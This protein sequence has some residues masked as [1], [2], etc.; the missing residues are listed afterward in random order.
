MLYFLL[1]AIIVIIVG[2]LSS[3]IFKNKQKKKAAN[4]RNQWGKVKSE[5]FNFNLISIYLENN[6]ESGFHQLSDQTKS[7]IDF[8]DI[9]CLIDRTVSK[10]GQQFLFDKCSRPTNDTNALEEL[11]KQVDFFVNNKTKR[12]VAQQLLASLNNNDAYFIATLLTDKLPPRPAWFN[13]AKVYIMAILLMAIAAV[14]YP[15]LIIWLMVPFGVNVFFHY[16]N[17]NHTQRFSK[18]FPQLNV[19]INICKKLKAGNLPFED[20]KV[21]ASIRNLRSIQQKSKL[22]SFDGPSL[23][24][25]LTQFA[26]IFFDVIKAFSLLE[27]FIFYNLIAAIEKQRSD[28]SHLFDYAGS[29]DTAL[30]IAS[31]RSSNFK[32]CVPVFLPASK[33][34]YSIQAYHPLIENCVS[35]N[36]EVQN[37]SILITGSNMSG[38]TTFLRMLAI[39]A[40]LA[41][42]ICTCF[43]DEFKT[44]VIKLHSSIRIDDNL[45]EGKSYYLE[46]VTIMGALINEAKQNWQ[47]IFILDEVFKGS[48]TI[49]RV[50]AAKAILSFLN[51]KNNMVFVSTHDVELAGMLA[52]EYELYHFAESIEDGQLSFGYTLKKGPLKTSNAIRILELYN[53]P[54]EIIEEA[55]AISGSLFIASSHQA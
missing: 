7:D 50:A 30:S 51:K 28:I 16:R 42:T 12:D 15:F 1:V 33:D 32:T 19:L 44:P 31:L 43:A 49:E 34:L 21:K 37:K 22:L 3:L 46:E 45:F 23:T 36:M 29:I 4:L 55:K 6:K 14:I 52:A 9:F 10:I 35:N 25:E 18:S 27:F 17:K 24:D 38:K 11:N 13:W 40:V 20:D 41:Q 53:Y 2:M 26:L 47:N 8:A 48:N 39:N 54:A 5:N